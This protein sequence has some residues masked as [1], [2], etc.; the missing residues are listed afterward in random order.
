MGPN[1][2]SVATD[3]VWDQLFMSDMTTCSVFAPSLLDKGRQILMKDDLIDEERARQEEAQQE[4]L[5]QKIDRWRR[6]FFVVR[7]PLEYSVL[8]SLFV[9]FNGGSSAPTQIHRVG[10]CW[11]GKYQDY[12]NVCAARSRIQRKHGV[13]DPMPDL[14][15]ISPYVH[16]RVDSNTFTMGNPMPVST[17]SL[18]QSRS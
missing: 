10:G 2:A 3:S 1:G 4:M 15:I 6:P 11:E 12:C 5:E 13:W 7:G 8:C 16:S 18:C 17:L 9:V 14:T